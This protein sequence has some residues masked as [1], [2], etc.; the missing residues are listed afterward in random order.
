MTMDQSNLKFNKKY[1]WNRIKYQS[2][3]LSRNTEVEERET[4]KVGIKYK[5]STTRLLT[6]VITRFTQRT[7]NTPQN[8]KKED[9]PKP[10]ETST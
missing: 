4:C 1:R 6:S 7:T 9:I 8:K 10:L 2:T 5:G 3:G